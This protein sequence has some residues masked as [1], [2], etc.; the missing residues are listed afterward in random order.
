M[1]KQEAAV[2]QGV[3]TMERQVKLKEHLLQGLL[4]TINKRE[5][6]CKAQ[7]V[8]DKV[9]DF[10]GKEYSISCPSWDVNL[11]MDMQQTTSLS[12]NF[13]CHSDVEWHGFSR[14]PNLPLSK[15]VKGTV[16]VVISVY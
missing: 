10:I 6:T 2:V 7:W 13:S 4:I 16:A 8:K 15:V 1:K 5:S 14:P 9:K 11:T 3:T 12:L